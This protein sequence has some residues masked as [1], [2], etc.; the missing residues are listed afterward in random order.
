MSISRFKNTFVSK[1]LVLLKVGPL[2]IVTS[3]KSMEVSFMVALS[4]T[5]SMWVLRIVKKVWNYSLELA[6]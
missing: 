4:L 2:K 5:V 6:R 3:K 1:W